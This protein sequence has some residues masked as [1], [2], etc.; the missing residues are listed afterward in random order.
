MDILGTVRTHLTQMVTWLKSHLTATTLKSPLLYLS[1]GVLAICQKIQSVVNTLLARIKQSKDQLVAQI[2]TQ[3]GL[4]TK[5]VSTRVTQ[6]HGVLGKLRQKV[7]SL[8]PQRVL[9]LL[10]KGQ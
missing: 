2:Q 9:K 4:L 10:K 8:I 6:I 3:V 5:H 1:I 7:V